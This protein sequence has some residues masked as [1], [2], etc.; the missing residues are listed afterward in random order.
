MKKI[1]INRINEDIYYEKLDNGLDVYLYVD[2]NI[3]NNYVTFTTKY[4][5]IYNEF[6]DN[7]GKM[8]KVPNG[9]AHFLEHKVFVQEN[10][11]QPE[12]FYGDMGGICNAYTTFKN[13][14]YLFSSTDNL[15]KGI[16][17]LLDFV[18][19]LYLTEESVESE[20]G[21]ITQEINMCDDKPMDILYEKIRKNSINKNPFKESII[22]ETDEINSIT[23]DLLTSCYNR[24]Y[25]PSNMFLV[26]TGNFD[27]DKILD[28]IK[29]NQS[30]KEF[31]KENK[32]ELKE[33]K[34]DDKIV[35]KY[36]VVK[37][38]TNIPKIAYTIKIPLDKFDMDIRKLSIYMYIIFNLLFGDTSSFDEEAKKDGII[39]NTLYYNILNIDS[40]FVIS[41]IN[42]TDKYKE[43]EERIDKEFKDIK[44]DERD[45]DRKKKVLISNEIF[46]YENIEMINEMI[47]DNI[48]FDNK[49]EDDIVS[50]I[51]SINIDELNDIVKKIDFNNKSV[52]IV[53]K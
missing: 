23:K 3:H 2:N 7:N 38:N 41:L 46:S 17:Y 11:P 49:I 16:E 13:T 29:N 47:I 8:I 9:I 39:T 4:G 33:Y 50:V 45:I 36:E 40:H 53:K 22:G 20:K 51:E 30:K 35:K 24:F 1:T 26:V 27:K 14:T 15:D 5:S 10:D 31:P 25:H 48:I 42:S 19:N 37:C 18:Q 52:V 44:F 21:I 6:K 32:I 12:E 28:V 43:L 34:E